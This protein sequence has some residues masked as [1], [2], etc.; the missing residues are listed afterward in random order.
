M[1][2]NLIK[3]CWQWLKNIISAATFFLFV[4]NQRRP[5]CYV[6]KKEMKNV[7]E[8]CQWRFDGKGFGIQS[9]SE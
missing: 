8:M 1:F 2:E 5:W 6:D 7:Q 9:E 4:N 3:R